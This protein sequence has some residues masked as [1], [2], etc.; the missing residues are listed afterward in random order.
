MQWFP[1]LTKLEWM[2]IF[3]LVIAYFAL[4]LTNLT[5]LPIFVDEA[6]YLR[7]AQIAWHDASWRFISLTDGKQP[8]Y[9]WFVI[10]FLK[11][12]ADPLAAGR[13]ASVVTGLGTVLG[14]GYLGWLIQGKKT[15]L[16]AML[17][18]MFSPYLF[19]YYRF[20]VMESMLVSGAIWV[21]NGSI[22][23]ARSRRLDVALLLGMWT[24]ATIL[25]KS[26]GMFFLLLIPVAYL[27]VV[28]FKHICSKQT[29]KYA[30]LVLISWF[31]ATVIYN[32]QR[33]SPWMHMIGQ[34]NAFFI[35]PYSEIFHEFGRLSNNFLDVWRWQHAYTTIPVLFMSLFGFYLIFRKNYRLGLFLSAWLFG[36]MLGTVLLAR[37]FAPRY[38]IFVTPFILLFTAYALAAIKNTKYRIIALFSLTLLPIYL[39]TR[40]ISDPIHFPYTS[41][42]QGYVNGW[43]AGNGT[44]QIADWAVARIKSTGKPMT[45]FTEG[46]FGI[47]PHGL[48]LYADGRVDGL[49]ITGLYPI[50]DIPPSHALQSVKTNPET[51]IILNNSYK[52]DVPS[53]LELVASYPKLRDNPMNL[54]RVLP[55]S[56]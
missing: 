47:L 33:L 1:R 32:V 53:G 55:S 35:V 3:G 12:I 24:G 17:L 14:M 25:V 48:E 10:P 51:Y 41:V 49:T 26:S 8:L 6:L 43:S 34:K 38:I 23:L 30:G 4:T 19:F 7:W 18:A 36:P 20:G 21:C 16:M 42:D 56:Q 52:K 22:L 50:T 15:A 11:F 9:V 28:D 39:I 37:L 46:T 54:Y 27:L 40:L 44:K 45:I 31:L 13:T 5:R 2:I 29:I